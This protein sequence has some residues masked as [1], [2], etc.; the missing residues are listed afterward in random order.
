VKRFLP[1]LRAPV[2]VCLLALCNPSLVVAETI[3]TGNVRATANIFAADKSVLPPTDGGAGTRPPGIKL[4]ATTYRVVTVTGISGEVTCCNTQK[5]S[6]FNRPEGRADARTNLS[7]IG[8]ISGVSM[9]SAMALVGVFVGPEPASAP[10]RTDTYTNRPAIGQVFYLGLRSPD[11][12]PVEFV[13]PEGATRFHLGIA[14]GFSFQ[15]KPGWYGDNAGSFRATVTV[16][17]LKAVSIES[18]SNG[19]GGGGADA[20]IPEA[21]RNSSE[22]SDGGPFADH[23]LVLWT[24]ACN[25]H[26]AGYDGAIV[27]DVVNGG[28]VNYR[29]WSRKEVDD[30]FRDDLQV[31]CRKRIPAKYDTAL[32]RCL[33]TGGPASFGAEYMYGLVRDYGE[34]NFDADP[35]QPGTQHIGPRTNN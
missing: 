9:R 5:P 31:L 17:E 20:A 8:G 2:A 13:V 12:V 16:R 14:D 22:F 18:V 24:Q 33:S 34:A 4:P 19:C 32:S 7:G 28:I 30:K 11:G 6:V 15:G 27:R 23:F 21:Y 10:P 1:A 26:D 3:K 25:L 29:G 35:A